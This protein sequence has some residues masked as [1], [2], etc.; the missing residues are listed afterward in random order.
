V[1]DAGTIRPMLDVRRLRVL[2]A[3]A[4]RGSIAAAAELL[5]YTPSAVSQQLFTLE[6]EIGI[7]LLE[8]G[9]R[10]VTLTDAG[11]ALVEH[12]EVILR[13]LEIAETEVLAIAGLEGGRLRMATFRSVGETLVADAIQTFSSRHPL[14]DLTL[15]E[16]EPEEYLSRVSH[17]ELDLGL[18]FEYDTVP[19]SPVRG[20]DRALLFREPMDVAVPLDHPVAGGDGVDLRALADEAWIASTPTSA[21][22]AFT[23]NVCRTAGFEPRV[24]FETNDYHVAQALVASGAGVTFLPRVSLHNLNPGVVALPVLG[25]PPMRADH[26]VNRTGG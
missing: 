13:R 7:A 23:Y 17:S 1:P 9:P 11:R 21:V 22:H 25:E 15:T 5:D 19:T 20:L 14:V 10:S 26:A 16:G 8:R 4:V 3:V 24:A 2:R 18:T 12:A 6:R